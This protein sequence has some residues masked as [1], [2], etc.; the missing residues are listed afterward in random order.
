MIRLRSHLAAAVALAALAFPAAA[1]GRGT[2][3]ILRDVSARARARTQGVQNYTINAKTMGMTL[4]SYVE[5][6]AEGAFQV[7]TVGSGEF[8]NVVSEISG[9]ADE[10]LSMME[11]ALAQVG[12]TQ[13]EMEALTC[14]GVVSSAGVS[15]HRISMSFA[16]DSVEEEG[17][18][19]PQRM[20]IDFDTATFL[21]RRLEVAMPR[22]PTGGAGMRMVAELGDWRSVEGMLIP[23]RR[24]LE[25]HGLRGEM[26]GED[27]T[28]A[29]G[30]LTQGRTMLA[31][32]PPEE[33][34]GMRQM[35]QMLEGVVKRDEMLLDEI[36]ISVAV[37]R[38]RPAGMRG[39]ND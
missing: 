24:H 19:M 11:N 39:K 29:N 10:M 2:A 1:Q 38:G 32:L 22:A 8:A 14:E 9:W 26:L 3:D 17:E 16:A 23:F 15:A 20:S 28:A 36:V 30:M 5:R 12:G 34:E 25:I 18:A 27:T 7:E 4:V 6:D 35:L 37:N 21:T 13:E 33:R 31:G